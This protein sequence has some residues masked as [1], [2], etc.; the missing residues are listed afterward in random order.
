[1]NNAASHVGRRAGSVFGFLVGFFKSRYRF[2]F[3]VTDSALVGSRDAAA[4]QCIGLANV[5]NKA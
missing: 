3:S 4:L 5:T 1:V 2:R